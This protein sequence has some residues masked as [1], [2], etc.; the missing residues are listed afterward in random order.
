MSTPGTNS[1]TLQ[2]VN[3]YPPGAGWDK[4]TK[5]QKVSNIT[6][7]ACPRH[8]IC[9]AAITRYAAISAAKVL[10]SPFLAGNVLVHSCPR[11]LFVQLALPISPH[12][13]IDIVSSS[14]LHPPA[15][16]HNYPVQFP[17]IASPGCRFTP[18]SLPF[19]ASDREASDESDPVPAGKR[20]IPAYP[21]GIAPRV[22]L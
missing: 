18:R 22:L 21:L 14:D 5:C 10:L 15:G 3:P 13:S 1:L 9:R 6:T 8:I 2:L 20:E 17:V 16:I 7:T 12:P 19:P 4:A 11:P